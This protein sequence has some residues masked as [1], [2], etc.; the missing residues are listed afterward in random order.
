MTSE[1][2]QAIVT[3][4]IAATVGGIVGWFG[5]Y[6]VQHRLHRRLSRID[7]LRQNLYDY[8]NLTSD[9]WHNSQGDRGK[10]QIQEGRLIVAQRVIETEYS[11]L[12]KGNKSAKKSY[13]DTEGARLSLWDSATG[14]CFGQ[15]DWNPCP[16][17][18]RS[19]ARAV[20]EIICSLE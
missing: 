11:L 10:R 12:A 9:Y 2:V 8:L 7:N 18:A 4:T 14:G 20:T 6:Y 5:N 15:A 19:A 17:R 3:A 1:F 16:D 13:A